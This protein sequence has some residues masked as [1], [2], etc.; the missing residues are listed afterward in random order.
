MPACR[1]W[2]PRA[3]GRVFH[4]KKGFFITY[5]EAPNLVLLLVLQQALDLA[6]SIPIVTGASQTKS[7][8]FKTSISKLKSMLCN[9]HVTDWKTLQR[10]LAKSP[11]VFLKDVA[12]ACFP[13]SSFSRPTSDQ[14]ATRRCGQTTVQHPDV[15]DH[16]EQT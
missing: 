4:H 16:Q 10:L 6:T 2:W 7:D 11:L 3:H 8:S 5:A 12:S 1:A 13:T 14:V 9:I 15:S